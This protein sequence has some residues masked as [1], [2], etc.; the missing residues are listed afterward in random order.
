MLVMNVK[1]EPDI[2]GVRERVIIDNVPRK[3]Y[4]LSEENIKLYRLTIPCLF[5]ERN[6]VIHKNQNYRFKNK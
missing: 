4:I 2:V 3:W 5:E 6:N 1:Y